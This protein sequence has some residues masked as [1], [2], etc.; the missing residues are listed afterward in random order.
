MTLKDKGNGIST[1]VATNDILGLVPVVVTPMNAMQEQGIISAACISN[2]CC[3]DGLSA[4]L[5]S[6]IST[7]DELSVDVS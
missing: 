1:V 4:C 7:S 3:I 5:S 2:Y 6:G